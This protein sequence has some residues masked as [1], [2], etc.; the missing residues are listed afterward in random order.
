MKS[1]HDSLPQTVEDGGSRME[2]GRDYS[3]SSILHSLLT[4]SAHGFLMGRGFNIESSLIASEEFSHDNDL[5]SG[6]DSRTAVP[7]TNQ[8]GNVRR[9]V[10]NGE[11]SCVACALDLWRCW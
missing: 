4:A 2:D 11:S 6:T 1:G 8:D 7:A 5:V 9:L 3:P 10:G